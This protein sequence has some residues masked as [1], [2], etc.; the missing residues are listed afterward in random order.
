MCATLASEVGPEIIRRAAAVSKTTSQ[1]LHNTTN[2]MFATKKFI[3]YSSSMEHCFL[4]FTSFFW[5]SIIIV[6]DPPFQSV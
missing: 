4:F 3:D 5:H 2:C 6:P 1:V